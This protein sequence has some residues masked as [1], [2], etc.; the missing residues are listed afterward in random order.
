VNSERGSIVGGSGVVFLILASNQSEVYRGHHSVDYP[1]D[2][3]FH[4]RVQIE[5]IIFRDD[6]SIAGNQK[7][8]YI[9]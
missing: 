2:C 5:P 3:L 7:A 9:S 8:I 4:F 1:S 6:G